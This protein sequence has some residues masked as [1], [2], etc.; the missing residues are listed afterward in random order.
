MK[1][2]VGALVL[3]AVGV[4]G[5]LSFSKEVLVKRTTTE[6]TICKIT[7]KP[8]DFSGQPVRVRA[9][10]DSDGLDWILLK[11]D[12]CPKNGINLEF[13]EGEAKSAS[14]KKIQNFVFYQE[15][16]GTQY[17][18]IY[19][20]FLGKFYWNPGSPDLHQRFVFTVD[21]VDNLS[22]SHRSEKRESPFSELR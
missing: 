14:F 2:I 12:N 16:S 4:V 15:P 13:S 17:K 11:D 3:S 5:A 21:R 20:N 7:Q 1:I 8:Q 9:Y 10:L 19:A 22:M 18:D 6:A